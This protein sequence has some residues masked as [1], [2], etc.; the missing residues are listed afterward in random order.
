MDRIS[1]CSQPS[2]ST[3]VRSDGPETPA[4]AYT[5]SHSLKAFN[6][7]TSLY[8]DPKYGL[9]PANIIKVIKVGDSFIREDAANFIFFHLNVIRNSIEC[10]QAFPDLTFNCSLAEKIFR[11]AEILEQRSVIDPIRLRMARIL[12]YQYSEQ[13]YKDSRS[14]QHMLNQRSSGRG[15]SSVAIDKILEEMY[16]QEKQHN[17]HIWEKRRNLFNKHKKLGRRWCMLVHCIGP[18]VLLICSSELATHM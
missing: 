4:Y 18:G 1:L 13:L 15:A 2:E 6:A 5:S 3:A 12:L 9:T 11:C 16:A 7:M 17:P 8:K 14:N 10:H